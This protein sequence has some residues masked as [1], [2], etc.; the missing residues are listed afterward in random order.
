VENGG[1]KFLTAPLYTRP[2]M[3]EVVTIPVAS[4]P[5]HVA[6]SLPNSELGGLRAIVSGH[7]HYDHLMDVPWVMTRAPSAMLYAN[8]TAK[9]IFAALAPDRAA[10]CTGAAPTTTLDRTRTI[11]MDDP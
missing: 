2:N 4:D 11:A 5:L 1:E 8:T 6:A 3:I 7:A 10:K 9:H